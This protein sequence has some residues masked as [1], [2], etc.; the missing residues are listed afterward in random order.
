[1]KRLLD[2]YILSDNLRYEAHCLTYAPTGAEPLMFGGILAA[3]VLCALLD[4][5][6]E[7]DAR[8]I[9][10]DTPDDRN[11]FFLRYEREVRR[12][13]GGLLRT[14]V[15]AL[16][17]AYVELTGE[18]QLLLRIC[19]NERLFDLAFGLTQDYMQRLVR[20]LV[21]EHI[22]DIFPW[23]EPFAQWLYDAAFVETR[24]QSLLSVNFADAIA[25]HA[26]ADS[27]THPD[28][29]EPV[30][31]TFTFE[32]LSAQHLLEGYY[33]W[34]WQTAQAITAIQPDA[35]I[36]LAE[37][38]AEILQNETDWRFLEDD[39]DR[40]RA[41]DRLSFRKWM[42][43]WEK[44]ITA[45]LDTS[46]RTNRPPKWDNPMIKQVLFLDDIMPIPPEHD[47]REV[48]R[49]IADRC[50]YDENFKNFYSN[51]TRVDFCN[52]LSAMFGWLVDPNH[53]GARL[54][55]KKKR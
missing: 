50:R 47:Y 9:A 29:D 45:Q 24:R 2:D 1:M 38:R 39:I 44:Y 32:G 20:E 16:H 17:L 42:T 49:Y 46:G 26:L 37:L 21:G 41:E 30:L 3:S 15:E 19:R 6:D 33:N 40:L 5:T 8:R 25:V 31:P 14:E 4:G 23:R 27:L 22:Y 7:G 55:Y 35:E 10:L 36:Q 11:D 12:D 48:C 18:E 28:A 52:Q 53:L 54:N 13:N 34:L 51:H 43:L